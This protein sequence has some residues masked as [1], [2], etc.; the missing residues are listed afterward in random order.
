MSNNHVANFFVHSFAVSLN[1]C[2]LLLYSWAISG[3]K[4]SSGLASVS[5]DEIESNTLEMVNAGDH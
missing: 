3:T 1:F 4:G 2:L 5:N